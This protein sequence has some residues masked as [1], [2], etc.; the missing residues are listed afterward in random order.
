VKLLF[1]QNLSYRLVAALDDL[2]PGSTHVRFQG[3]ERADDPVIWQFAKDRGYAI[4]SKDDDFHQRSFL[5]GHPPKVIWLRLRNC[6][7]SLIESTLRRHVT[8]ILAFD[9]DPRLAFLVL[10]PDP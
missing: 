6:P 4:V 10:S 5:Y 3:M 9:T 8:D 7:T 1:D 2:F